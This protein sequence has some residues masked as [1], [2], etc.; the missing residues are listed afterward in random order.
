MKTS[1]TYGQIVKV[2]YPIFLTVLV[3]NLIQAIDT[4]FLGHVGEVELGASAIG[5]I[6]YIAI[7]VVVFGFSMGAQIL[8]GRRNGEKNYNQIGEIFLFGVAFLLIIALLIFCFTLCFSGSI[9]AK[10][11]SSDNILNASR[12]YLDWRIGGVFFAAVNVMFRAFFVGIIKTK[13][14]TFNAVLMALA[15]V[16]F[17]YVLIFGKWGFPEMGIGGAGLASVFAESVSSLFFIIYLLVSIDL[18]K[19]GFAGIALK[20]FRI[21]LNIL[22]ISSALMLQYFISLITWLLFFLAIESMGETSLAVSNIIRSLYMMIGIPIFALSATSSTLV[23]NT[24]GAGKSN[25]VISLI[26]KIISLSFCISLV[27]VTVIFLFPKIILQLYTSNPDII[28]ASIPSL[29]V[30]LLV[31]LIY[32][33]GNIL[34]QSVSGTGNTRSGLMIETSVIV[35]YVIWMWFTAYYLKAPLSVCWTVELI[36]AFFLG[37]F[38]LLYFKYGKWQNKKI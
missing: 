14:L 24:I 22:N 4:A 18:K 17:D 7:F 3:Q 36:Y 28:E 8:I 23:S 6:F 13:V 19:Y 9:L 11:L 2:A 27:I 34:F 32:S 25:E 26:G 5:G 21:I 38:S 15:N 35:L 16:F 12:E 31:L 10:L 33:A 30:I 1:Y 20:N 37:L 29:N